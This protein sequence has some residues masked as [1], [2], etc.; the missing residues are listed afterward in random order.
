MRLGFDAARRRTSI[1]AAVGAL[2]RRTRRLARRSADLSALAPGK[3]RRRR[4]ASLRKQKTPRPLRY[5]KPA[6]SADHREFVEPVPK[7]S[8]CLCAFASKPHTHFPRYLLF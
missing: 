5:L 6:Q 7:L 1:F 3:V 8:Q 2:G 4:T